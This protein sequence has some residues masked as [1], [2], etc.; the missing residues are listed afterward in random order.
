MFVIL[1][2]GLAIVLTK[3]CSLDRLLLINK[4]LECLQ[5]PSEWPSTPTR[6]SGKPTQLHSKQRLLFTFK[7]FLRLR[8]RLDF[9][10]ENET[11]R[12]NNFGQSNK[13]SMIIND[14]Y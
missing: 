1:A 3:D 8:A 4:V 12:G 10:P 6:F 9:T 14:D 13:C 5:R 7:C 11:I 2:S